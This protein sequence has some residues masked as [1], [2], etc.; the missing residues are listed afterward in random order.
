MRTEKYLFFIVLFMF[1]LVINA[2]NTELRF[3]NKPRY[4]DI[5]RIDFQGG[6]DEI[7]D[8]ITDEIKVNLFS[9]IE[10]LTCS[11]E[12]NTSHPMKWVCDIKSKHLNQVEGYFIEEVQNI[13]SYFSIRF[14]NFII[15]KDRNKI[16]ETRGFFEAEKDCSH[17]S[18]F[19][20]CN[21]NYLMYYLN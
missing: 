12:K 6:V 16:A 7:Y 20:G 1:S 18:P 17:S 15:Y 21:Y 8:E 10:V 19:S 3:E 4:K 5:L 14:S 11:Y 9:F 13:K 2:Q